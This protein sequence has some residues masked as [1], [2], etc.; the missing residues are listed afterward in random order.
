MWAP[1]VQLKFWTLEVLR[2]NPIFLLSKTFLLDV[3]SGERKSTNVK[4]RSSKLSSGC[5]WGKVFRFSWIWLTFGAPSFSLVT[6]SRIIFFHFWFNHFEHPQD[7]VSVDERLRPS[8][9]AGQRVPVVLRWRHRPSPEERHLQG[10]DR[11]G[12]CKR[13]SQGN[14]NIWIISLLSSKTEL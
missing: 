1:L 14:P 12:R 3:S 2:S 5:V 9:D 4:V 7:A 6:F 13:A 10:Q 8:Q 11:H